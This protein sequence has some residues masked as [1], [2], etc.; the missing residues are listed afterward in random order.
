MLTSILSPAVLVLS[1]LVGRLHRR[2][3]CSIILGI[4]LQP[5]VEEMGTS[6]PGLIDFRQAW[7]SHLSA[8]LPYAGGH[9]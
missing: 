7:S 6:L 1:C 9:A 5:E 2:I 3:E 8:L 4:L